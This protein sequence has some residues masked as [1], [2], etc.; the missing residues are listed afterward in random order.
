MAW[1][2]SETPHDKTNMLDKLSGISVSQIGCCVETVS[3]GE[4]QRV[5]APGCQTSD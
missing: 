4:V 1:L 2:S 5:V 3:S